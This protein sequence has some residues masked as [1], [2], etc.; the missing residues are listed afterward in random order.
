MLGVCLGHQTIAEALSGRIVRAKEPMHGR[1]SSVYHDGRGIFAGLPSPLVGCRYHSLTVDRGSL[2]E[3]LELTAWTDDGTV[4]AV[5]HRQWPTV[6][7]QF[8]P[9]SILTDCGYPLLAAFL[10]L[11]G[12]RVPSHLPGIDHE[13]AEPPVA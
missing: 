4:M 12:L 13:R 5:Q 3:C 10:Q 9:E 11:A 8:H 1:T 6:G 7:L 2:P